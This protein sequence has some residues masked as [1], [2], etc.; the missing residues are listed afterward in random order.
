MVKG[1]KDIIN[2]TNLA[3]NGRFTI[4]QRNLFSTWTQAKLNDVLCDGWR[5]N[6]INID[7]LEAYGST[8]ESWLQFRGHGKKGQYVWIYN[9]GAGFQIY[10][11][12]AYSIPPSNFT[13]AITVRGSSGVPLKITTEPAKLTGSVEIHTKPFF[14]ANPSGWFGQAVSIVKNTNNFSWGSYGGFYIELLADGEF[15]VLVQDFVHFLG[16]YFNPPERCPVPHSED[17]LRCQRYY[18]KGFVR[19]DALGTSNGS[20]YLLGG[21]VRLHTMAG[22]PSIAF[23]NP[24]VNEEGSATNEQANYTFASDNVDTEGFSWYTAKAIAG[25]K[26]RTATFNWTATI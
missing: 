13:A 14:P 1:F 9:F 19:M 4:K 18:Q 17:L 11:T 21:P 25:S 8:N 6:Y 10:N 20:S 7:F 15:S 2:P 24:T 16:C 26:P 3:T 23:A 22:T 12:D 5:V